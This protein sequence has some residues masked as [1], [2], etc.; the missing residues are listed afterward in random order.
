MTRNQAL[1]FDHM[2]ILSNTKWINGLDLDKRGGP[3]ALKNQIKF[4]F[5]INILRSV[6]DQQ[7]KF[8]LTAA[9]ELLG[10]SNSLGGNFYWPTIQ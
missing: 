3:Y 5:F 4:L 6:I 10:I 1:I 9:L 2:A 8:D 7:F